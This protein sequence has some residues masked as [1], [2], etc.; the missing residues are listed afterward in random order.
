MNFV[1][2]G[3][4]SCLLVSSLISKTVVMHFNQFDSSLCLFT[5]SF[6]DSTAFT[7]NLEVKRYFFREVSSAWEKSLIWLS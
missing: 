7:T 6:S 3:R 1:M 5:N 4:I 2:I